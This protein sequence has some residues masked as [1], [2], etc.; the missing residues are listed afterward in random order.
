MVVFIE[1]ALPFEEVQFNVHRKKNNWEQGTVTAIAPRVVAARAPRLP[2]LR[3]ACRRLR[4]LQD[5]APRCSGAGRGQAARAR[6]QPLAPRQGA[7]RQRAAARSKDLPGTTAI[8]RACRC[9]TWSKKGTVL[10]GFH[11]RKSRYLADMK[12]C[13]VLPAQVSDMLHAVARTDR[14]DGRARDL[15]ADRTGLRRLARRHGARV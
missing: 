2:A 12:V 1:G 13:P 9:V 6:G 14:I 11:E 10:I 5:A 8:A 4:R 3:L 15:P 7:A